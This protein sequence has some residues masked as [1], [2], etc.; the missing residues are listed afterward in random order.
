ML[1][2]RERIRICANMENFTNWSGSYNPSYYL[3]PGVDPV[4]LTVRGATIWRS[5]I[6]Y[7][8]GLCGAVFPFGEYILLSIVCVLLGLG[9]PKVCSP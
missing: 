6:N 1:Y 3:K 2:G 5:L 9:Q 7:A 8:V 4:T